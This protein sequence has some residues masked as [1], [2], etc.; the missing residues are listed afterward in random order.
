MLQLYVRVLVAAM[1]FADT[2]PTT[3]SGKASRVNGVAPVLIAIPIAVILALGLATAWFMYC[4][5]RGMWPALDMPNWR[6][7]GT[8]KAYCKR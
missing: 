8:I 6:E 7:G 1:T 2:P 5:R 4:Q 3:R